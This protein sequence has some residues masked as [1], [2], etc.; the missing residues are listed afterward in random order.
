MSGSNIASGP[1]VNMLCARFP[2]LGKNASETNPW[3]FWALLISIKNPYISPLMSNQKLKFNG[4]FYCIIVLLA[5]M[6]HYGGSFARLDNLFLDW[7]FRFLQEKFPRPVQNDV[8]IIGIDNA[9]RR[10]LKEPINLWHQ[11]YGKFLRAMALAKPK[12]V[13]LDILL[14]DRSYEFLLPGFDK[15][16]RDGI[17]SARES[18]KVI[19]GRS[20][21]SDN[22]PRRIFGRYVV[23]MGGPEFIGYAL[24]SRDED[25]FI[26]RYQS[27]LVAGD[28]TTLTLTAQI[29]RHLNLPATKGIIDYSIGQPFS[30]LS[31]DEVLQWFEQ[32]DATRLRD[33]FQDKI[34]LL[35]AVL[36][37][38]DRHFVPVNLAAWEKSLDSSDRGMP[39][40]L[41]HGQALRSYINNG[42]I[43]PL[44]FLAMAAILMLATLVVFLYRSLYIGSMILVTSAFCLTALSTYVLYYGSYLP[45]TS[46]LFVIVVAFIGTAGFRMSTEIRERRRLRSAFN[47]YVS[48]Q[49]MQEILNGRL[50]GELG[51]RRHH[52][53]VLFSDIRDFTQRSET[54]P[55]E[56]IISLL[57]RYFGRMSA[58]IHD[59][60]GTLDKFIGD[61]IMAFFGAPN[62]MDNPAEKAFNAA[63]QMLQELSE[64]N[65]EL[66]TEGIPAIEFGV[67]LHLGFAVVGHV[68]SKD[69]HEYTAIGDVVNVTAR[70]ES[71]TK[72]TGYPLL[73]TQDVINNLEN[74]EEFLNLGAQDIKGHTAIEV[75]AWDKK[76]A[77]E[78]DH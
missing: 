40:V 56:H 15:S 77:T 13:G 66:A 55:A 68:G 78:K 62:E 29:A 16:L 74:K 10:A 20:L 3:I 37:F 30:Y 53:C 47:A 46:P 67:G 59:Q 61:G 11:H 57:N 45:L 7:Q 60:G 14:P 27:M 65:Q 38:E 58:V 71:L 2:I 32:G 25:L 63:R 18:T 34:V 70:V 8:L 23:A 72:Q 26:R 75:F 31:F 41:V 6:F 33:V 28:E 69:R 4:L 24:L 48:P 39:G 22:T 36:P 52:I 42:L 76:A 50:K 17:V 54:M 44:P 43:Q 12:V 21:D 35:G 49:I 1:S 5:L 64:L 9:S 51:G 73:C 19:Y